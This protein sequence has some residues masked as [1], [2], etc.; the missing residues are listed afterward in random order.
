MATESAAGPSAAGPS[1]AQKPKYSADRASTNI[2]DDLLG[3]PTLKVNHHRIKT[4]VDYLRLE[5]ASL[6][7]FQYEICKVPSH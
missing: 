5:W 6:Q 2:K 7:T 4:K 3:N 1:A